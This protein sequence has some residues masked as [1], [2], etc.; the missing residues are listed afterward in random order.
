[1]IC[2][3]QSLRRIGRGEISC[4]RCHTR[5]VLYAEKTWALRFIDDGHRLQVVEVSSGLKIHECGVEF[6]WWCPICDRVHFGD[7]P[8]NRN[9][10]SRRLEWHPPPCPNCQAGE[11]MVQ[12]E[13]RDR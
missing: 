5:S 11:R 12:R 1:M 8:P 6:E 9:F 2:V 4:Y 13:V 7:L 10:R 3:D